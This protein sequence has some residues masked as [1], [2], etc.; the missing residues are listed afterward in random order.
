[1][2]FT[3]RT[4]R[5]PYEAHTPIIEATSGCTYNHCRFCSLFKN[6]PFRM[7]SIETFEQDLAEI[8]RYQPNARRLFWT[9]ANPFAMSADEAVNSQVIGSF[10]CYGSGF[11][12]VSIKAWIVALATLIARS[13][14]V[15]SLRIKASTSESC[16]GFSG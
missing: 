12:A 4:W 6:E 11:G 9:G 1:M 15:A 3:G 8:K 10:A 16:V 5:P 13:A 2:H 14:Q 7:S